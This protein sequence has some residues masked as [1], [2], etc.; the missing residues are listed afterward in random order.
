MAANLC[1]I[2]R[3]T[4]HFLRAFQH[5]YRAFLHNPWLCGGE[6]AQAPRGHRLLLP[7]QFGNIYR[8]TAI[9]VEQL[10]HYR[11]LWRLV[12]AWVSAHFSYYHGDSITCCAYLI[13]VNPEN[14]EKKAKYCLTE[15]AFE[16]MLLAID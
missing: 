3:H 9:I 13:H 5:F 11:Q 2:T 7:C 16:N 14:D 8:D 1:Y 12:A 4:S 15:H 10:L 6:K